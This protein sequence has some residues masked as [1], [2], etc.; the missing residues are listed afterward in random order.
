MGSFV[1]L[2]ERRLIASARCSS[3]FPNGEIAFEENK[4]DPPSRA[5]LKLY[6][7]LTLAGRHPGPGDRCIDS[8]ACPGGWTW[9]LS[10]LGARVTA[11]DRTELDPRLMKDPK[12]EF[13]KHSA[14]TLSPADLGKTDWLFSDVI[15]Y[16]EKLYEWIVAWLESGLCDNF[17]CTIKMQGEPDWETMARFKAIPGSRLIHLSNNKHELTWIRLSGRPE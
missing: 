10:R 6:E 3:P 7:A 5:Y 13:L 9:V 16:P 2:D 12:V 15:C 4:V 11:I 1:L 8:G 14:F 17:V